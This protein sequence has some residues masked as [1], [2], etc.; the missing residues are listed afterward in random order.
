MFYTLLIRPV[1]TAYIVLYVYCIISPLRYCNRSHGLLNVYKQ[2]TS[3][4]IDY[5]PS[6]LCLYSNVQ[7]LVTASS[8]YGVHTI[9]YITYAAPSMLTLTCVLRNLTNQAFCFSSECRLVLTRKIYIAHTHT[10]VEART[11]SRATHMHTED[12]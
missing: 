5:L 3:V 10:Y 2:Y 4:S 11:H 7:S 9:L 8:I 1:H 12:C 6:G